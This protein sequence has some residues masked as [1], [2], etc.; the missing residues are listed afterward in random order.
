[1]QADAADVRQPHDIS[2]GPKPALLALVLSP[3]AATLPAY[4]TGLRGVVLVYF[5]NTE[6]LV[7]Q[8]MDDLRVRGRRDLLSLFA[9]EMLCGVVEGLADHDSRARER[10]RGTL[11]GEMVESEDGKAEEARGAVHRADR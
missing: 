5:T 9:T 2:W 1:M 4:R 6:T 7:A 8:L 11:A 10:G 3:H